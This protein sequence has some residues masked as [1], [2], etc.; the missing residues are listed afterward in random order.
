MSSTI[1][2]SLHHLNFFVLFLC[3][4]SSRVILAYCLIGKQ[5]HGK[6]ANVSRTCIWYGHKRVKYALRKKKKIFFFFNSIVHLFYFDIECCLFELFL[7]VFSLFELFYSYFKQ[8][9]IVLKLI[10]D[11]FPNISLL[12]HTFLKSKINITYLKYK[13]YIPKNKY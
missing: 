8:Y 10:L 9:F 3:F 5:G 12:L 13:I 11:I 2:S 6:I 4:L 1:P 7:W